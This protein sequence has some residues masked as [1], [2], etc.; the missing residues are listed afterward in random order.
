VHCYRVVEPSL[1]GRVYS[2]FKGLSTRPGV[3]ASVQQGR[4]GRPAVCYPDKPVWILSWSNLLLMWLNGVRIKRELF[5]T[6]KAGTV[7]A[8]HW[9]AGTASANAL[10]LTILAA[11][12]W[13]PP[14]CRT[15]C[16]MDA[17]S[18]QGT[19]PDLAPHRD[20]LNAAEEREVPGSHDRALGLRR[21]NCRSN[22][23]QSVLIKSSIPKVTSHVR[24]DM[25]PRR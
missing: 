9:N 22:Y 7:T 5:E 17:S 24:Y 6:D 13:S 25:G 18:S 23:R 8:T 14:S 21:K 15:T 11:P 19:L 12:E 4:R 20:N 10:R 16:W 1:T 2:D 3:L